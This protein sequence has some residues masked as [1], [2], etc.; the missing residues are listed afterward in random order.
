MTNYFNQVEREWFLTRV[1]GATAQTPIGQM[2]RTYWIS[3]L[4]STASNYGL[5]D[6]ES[7]WLVKVI[8]DAGDTPS[9]ENSMATLWKE[10]VIA[11]G[12]TPSIRMTENQMTFYKNA[13]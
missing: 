8:I 12:K 10:A 5:G 2:K 13:S 4:G 3:Q 9:D 11:I 6:L 7:R 1:T